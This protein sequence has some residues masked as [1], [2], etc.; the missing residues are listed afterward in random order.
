MDEKK[1]VK[2]IGAAWLESEGGEVGPGD[3]QKTK[4]E[5]KCRR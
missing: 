4:V 3:T 2:F 1:A 5:V